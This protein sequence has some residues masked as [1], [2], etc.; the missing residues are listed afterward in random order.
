[1]LR[2]L[3]VGVSTVLSEFLDQ[4]FPFNLIPISNRDVCAILY[5]DGQNL[6]QSPQIKVL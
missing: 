6:L 2:G 1:M 5:A 3:G 4:R